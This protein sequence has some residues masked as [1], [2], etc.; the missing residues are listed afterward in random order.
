ML[1]KHNIH[2]L[3]WLSPLLL[4]MLFTSCAWQQLPPSIPA[5]SMRLTRHEAT[6]MVGDTLR[7]G[8]TFEPDSVS[9]KTAFWYV[10]N[11][12]AITSD[13]EQGAVIGM[14]M[15]FCNVICNAINNALSDTCAVEVLNRWDGFDNTPFQYDMVVYADVELNGVHND[16]LVMVGAFLGDQLRG[17]GTVMR[18]PADGT[19]TRI[20]VWHT[21]PNRGTFTF[22]Y[23]DRRNSVTGELNQELVFDGEMHGTPSDPIYMTEK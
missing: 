19:V 15:G 10:D 23:H 9:N 16:S 21:S 8:L 18:T 22:R 5:T 3:A 6:V 17:Y 20:R 1:A 13:S 7:L 14:Q 4:L 11:V 2:R 12:N